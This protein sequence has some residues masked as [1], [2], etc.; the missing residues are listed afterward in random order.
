MAIHTDNNNQNT[1]EGLLNNTDQQG[2]FDNKGFGHGP[3]VEHNSGMDY[4][5]ALGFGQ[6][7]GLGVMSS[8]QGSDYTNQIATSI[9]E[10]YNKNQT[11]TNKP[12]VTILDKE[13]ITTNSGVKLAYSAIVVSLAKDNAV[14]Y[15]TILLEN[16]GRAPL[17]AQD[18]MSEVNM[19]AKTNQGR[20]SIYTTDD[21]IDTIL[22]QV[23]QSV[24]VNDYGNNYQFRSVEGMVFRN[25]IQDIQTLYPRLAAI[26]YNACIVEAML[27]GSDVKDINIETANHKSHGKSLRIDSVMGKGISLN[28]I[29]S[30][31]RT[32]FKIDLNI[33]DNNQS[34]T[35][36]NL[37]NSKIPLTK[38]GGFVDAIPELTM[39]PNMSGMTTN[40]MQALRLRPHIILT[41]FNVAIPTIG[42]SMLALVSA[43]VMTNK[44]MW[45]SAL[46]P[47]DSKNIGA[48]NVMTNIEGNANSIGE[49]I[50]F[51]KKTY[52]PEDVYQGIRTMFSLDP[53]VSVDVD[54]FGPQTFFTSILSTIA[55]PSNSDEK[56]AASS[57]FI[58]TLSWLTSG[59][60]PRDFNP[61][62]IF[63]S[64]GVVLP[65]GVWHDKTGMRDLREIDLA[66][67][68]NH[69]DD[70]NIL[71]RWV[72]SGAPMNVSHMDSYLTR[73]EIISKL[74]PDAVIR[75]K[76]VRVT[77]TNKFIST[78]S[79]AAMGS[80]LSI[81]YE[82]EI[83][84][85]EDNNLAVMGSYLAGAGINNATGF[86]KEYIQAGPIFNTNY[87]NAGLYRYGR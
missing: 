37:Q 80:G 34:V 86:A 18:I 51:S 44:N 74:I 20:A 66:F 58:E 35:S 40:P 49:K 33:M 72:L 50:D 70:I 27:S 77:F 45:V 82:P 28:E 10:I 79:A 21:A 78:L 38:T 60:F 4:S 2:Q 39:L 55:Q 12:K 30:P 83:K 43:L 15:Y 73:V 24:L 69:V 67:L 32:D 8:N 6:S 3:S 5:K 19:A 47:K 11:I 53:V 16:T 48:L 46:L 22:H 29:G 9:A 7:S 23:I 63:V 14:N 75:G 56:L 1:G 61:A 81:R 65:S 25:D 26:A 59:R 31:V 52:K 62:E 54:S 17:T 76:F 84:F 42:Y 57:H 68:A 13:V 64:S 85:A 41:D 71:N 36:L 87:T